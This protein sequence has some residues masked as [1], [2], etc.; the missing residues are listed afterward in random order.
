MNDR[1]RRRDY[2]LLNFVDTPAFLAPFFFENESVTFGNLRCDIGLD[3]LI[4]VRE[5]VERHQFGDELMR[6]QT[7]LDREL[8]HNDRRLD[9]NDV[10]RRRFGFGRSRFNG[11]AVGCRS[12]RLGGLR[13]FRFWRRNGCA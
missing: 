3:R 11:R 9:V 12:C 4:D 1:F 2:D 8:L 7:E 5:D 13:R 10:L 6:F